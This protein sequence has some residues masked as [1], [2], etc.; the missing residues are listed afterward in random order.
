MLAHV[1]TIIFLAPIWLNYTLPATTENGQPVVGN[2]G[3]KLYHGK[4]VDS[5]VEVTDTPTGTPGE[6]VRLPFDTDETGKDFFAA[7]A[8][9][10]VTVGAQTIRIESALSVTMEVP[11]LGKPGP[12]TDQSVEL[13]QP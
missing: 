9:R 10:D 11:D 2:V 3:S 12:P 13:R 7:L 5:L 8:Y 4:A 1:L 6:V